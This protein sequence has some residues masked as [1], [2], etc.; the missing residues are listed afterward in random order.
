MKAFVAAL[1]LLFPIPAFAA[2][3]EGEAQR[4]PLNPV[5]ILMFV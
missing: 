4:Q 5:A 2:A 1:A 3:L